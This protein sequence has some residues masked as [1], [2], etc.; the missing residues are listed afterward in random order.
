MIKKKEL[1]R[2][3]TPDIIWKKLIQKFFYDF[4]KIFKPDLLKDII[5]ERTEFLEK[6]LLSLTG[7]IKKGIVDVLAK[8]YLKN[9]KEEYLLFHIEVQGNSDKGFIERMFGYY[10][11]IWDKFRKPVISL[12]LIVGKGR[13]SLMNNKYM[14]ETYGTK[15]YYE[16]NVI[17]VSKLDYVKSISSE[18]PV[19]VVISILIKTRE[20]P[21]WKRKVNAIMQ[22]N[23]LGLDQESINILLAFVD[24]IQKLNNREMEKFEEYIIKEVKEVKMILTSWEEKGIKKGRLEGIQE[25]ILK[26]RQEGILEGKQEGI[27]KGKREGMVVGKRE[28]KLEGEREKVLEIAQ[29]MIKEGFEIGKISKITG[30]DKKK[31]KTLK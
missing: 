29:K 9:G 23:R 1:D 20:V 27:L 25:G 5:I 26:G 11:R 4:L 7:K 30:L 15:L 19:E 12:A 2:P 17:D 18:N 28:G 31:L 3:A 24:R 16:Y 14:M 13:K 22:L 6:E 10:I 8:V 21:K